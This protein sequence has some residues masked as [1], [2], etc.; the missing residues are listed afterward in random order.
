M[1]V[2]HAIADL[3]FVS[4]QSTVCIIKLNDRDMNVDVANYGFQLPNF[5]P[6]YSKFRS[7]SPELERCPIC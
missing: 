6:G 3:L 1:P 4:F 5:K 7:V 2:L